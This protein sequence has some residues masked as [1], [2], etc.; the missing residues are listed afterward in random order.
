[1]ADIVTERLLGEDRDGG[2]Q[3]KP[4]NQEKQP[5][6]DFLTPAHIIAI[7]AIGERN[8]DQGRRGLAG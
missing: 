2:E 1:M 4:G 5:H 7:I 3:N 6:R 8:R